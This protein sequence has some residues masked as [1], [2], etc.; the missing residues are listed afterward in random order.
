M[1]KIVQFYSSQIDEEDT[2]GSSISTFSSPR[3]V[4][5]SMALLLAL[6]KSRT[7]SDIGILD[8]FSFLNQ[9]FSRFL[10][11]LRPFLKAL[12]R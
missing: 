7:C 6:I 12:F 10:V 3:L 1:Y 9:L 2:T 8:F 5:L 4:G 11:H